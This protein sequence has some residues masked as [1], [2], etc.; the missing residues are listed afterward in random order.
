MIRQVRAVV[1]RSPSTRQIIRT[2]LPRSSS[3]KDL[4]RLYEAKSSSY[5]TVLVPPDETWQGGCMQLYRAAF[6]VAEDILRGVTGAPLP[7]R[8]LE[9]RS[10]DESGVDGVGYALTQ[11]T[12]PQ[13][14]V[15]CFVQPTQETLDY[16]KKNCEVAKG[17][18]VMLHNPQWRDVDDA[19]DTASKGGGILGGFASF[20]GGKGETLKTLDAMGFEL[21]YCFDGYVCKGGDVWLL[22]HFDAPWHVFAE[23]DDKTDYIFLGTK[24]TRPSYQDVDAM[25]DAK[26]ITVKYAR[27]IGMAPKL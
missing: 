16:I 13:N 4:G 22:K 23:N 11:C 6:P 24:Q 18:L 15:G 8:V 5:D 20:L 9:D 17:R 27:D 12:D 21:T 14:D 7:P 25:L 1:N 3:A 19:L 2:P 26:G 10:C